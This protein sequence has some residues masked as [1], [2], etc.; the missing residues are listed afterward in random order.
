MKRIPGAK[1]PRGE[2]ASEMEA[3]LEGEAAR[4]KAFG[5]VTIPLKDKKKPKG[6]KG[7]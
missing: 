5:G 3:M 1:K 7:K 4:R 6:G 2:Y